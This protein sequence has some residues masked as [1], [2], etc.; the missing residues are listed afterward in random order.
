MLDQPVQILVNFVKPV[1]R[2]SGGIE[3]EENK[4]RVQQIGDQLF[5]IQLVSSIQTHGQA[6][7]TITARHLGLGLS[8]I[9]R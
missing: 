9:A 6:G 4:D 7:Q 5:K 1:Q 2:I 8:Q 3:G